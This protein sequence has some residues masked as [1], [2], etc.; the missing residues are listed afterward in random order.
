MADG[1]LG[2]GTGKSNTLNQEL[3][4]KLKAADRKG[5]VEPL[6]RDLENLKKENEK[7]DEIM[8]KYNALLE[9]IKNFDLF[10][11]SGINALQQKSAS[12]TGS[13]VVFDAADVSKLG[14]GTTTVDIKG[15]AQRDVFQS[16]TFDETTRKEGK[17]DLGTLSIAVGSGDA[18]NIDTNGKT[19]DQVLA[20]INKVKG[21]SASI[22]E[23]GSGTYRIVIKSTNTG[24]DNAL[25]I[26]GDAGASLGYND[27]ANHT[28][29]AKNMK[30][31]VD[32]VEYESSSN[33]FTI[34]G[35][36]KITA[37]SIGSSSLSVTDDVNGMMDG[38]Q[39]FVDKYNEFVKMVQEELTNP[40]TPISD[41]SSIRSLLDGIQNIVLGSFG[42]GSDEDKVSL[43]NFGFEMD[44]N[45]FEL[46][47]DS[48]K[49][50]KAFDEN[51]DEVYDLFIGKAESKGLG[52]QL[53][54]Y[55]N[56][57]TRTDG[58]YDSYEKYLKK[59]EETLNDEK[60]KAISKLDTKYSTMAS[61]FAEYTAI[62][63]K[64]E[65][66]FSGLQLMIAQ[67]KA[68]N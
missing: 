61:Q 55:M 40:E 3:I 12:Q 68:G 26:S 21:V 43:F 50:Q 15:L 34:S 25:T 62:I 46:K 31:V 37:T 53:V 28:L 17:V 9:A 57:Q 42:Q 38:I 1:I 29:V 8:E 2:L 60:E 64:M 35:G 14:T 24:T 48:A 27:S 45:T 16:N 6:E 18:V 30:A 63:T 5:Q 36:L 23:V 66:S 51:F 7:K 32:G 33:T 4:D 59:R 65:S 11:T 20:E 13:S 39:N 56:D 44:T 41:K 67:S 54:E 10:T 19:Y 47:F 49:L 52:T 22:E 58:I